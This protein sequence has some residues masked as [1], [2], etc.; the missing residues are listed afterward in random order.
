M[1]HFRTNWKKVGVELEAL[2]IP[3]NVRDDFEANRNAGQFRTVCRKFGIAEDAIDFAINEIE[4]WA[5]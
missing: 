1:K 3:Q 4:E 5:Q 2:S